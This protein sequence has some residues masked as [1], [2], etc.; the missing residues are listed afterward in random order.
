MINNV[1]TNGLTSTI[2]SNFEIVKEEL[3]KAGFIS[4]EKIYCVACSA[5]GSYNEAQIDFET[6][7]YAYPGFSPYHSEVKSFIL[8]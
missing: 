5:K 3:L 7:R 6:F 2:S 8:P 1:T 4:G